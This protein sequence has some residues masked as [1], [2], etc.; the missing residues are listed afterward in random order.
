MRSHTLS[1]TQFHRILLTAALVA[2]ALACRYIAHTDIPILC[3]NTANFIRFFLYIGLFSVW[4]L[5][6]RRRVILSVPRQL[7]VAVSLF[8]ILWLVIREY[9]WHLIFDPDIG[10]WLWYSYYIPLLF[11]PYLAFL[12]SL[13]LGRD[14]SMRLSEPILATT[15]I[16]AGLAILVITND[17]HQWVFR[18]PEEA[19]VWSEDSYAY[20]P[21][22]A[23]IF[24]WNMLI[25]LV[26]LAILFGK[27]RI[28]RSKRLIWL[29]LIC[30][31]FDAAYSILYALQPLRLPLFL[32][33]TTVIHCLLFL[34]FFESCIQCGLIQSNILYRDLLRSSSDIEVQITDEDYHICF[35]SQ[36]TSPFD[37]IRIHQAME[38]PVLLPEGKY[39]HNMPIKGGHVLWTEDVSDFIRQAQTL[40]ERR[41]ELKDRSEFLQL[42]YEKEKEHRAVEEQNRLYDL[43]QQKTQS[44][45]D[46]ITRLAGAYPTHSDEA[47]KRR[48]LATIIVLGSFIKRQKDFILS[49]VSTPT[50]SDEKLKS[51][52][53]ESFRALKLAGIS[54]GCFIQTQNGQLPGQQIMQCFEFFECIVERSLFVAHFLNFRIAETKGTLRCSIMTDADEADREELQKLYPLLEILSPEDGGTEYLLPLKCDGKGGEVDD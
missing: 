42:E 32:G 29:P 2:G 14:G 50:L 15:L 33:D 25:S 7:L 6:V 11:I 21:L 52:L 23:V 19:R 34:A 27:C 31:G 45:L 10:R 46:Q 28:P 18:F 35:A 54:G 51:A 22:F 9:R 17:V 4:G 37:P 48:I 24:A 5:S 8:M 12:V 40:A 43:L 47:E 39:L 38:A 20:G 49:A 16:P 53:A 13:S 26:T 41:D 44:Q 1:R 36:N 3:S 30:I